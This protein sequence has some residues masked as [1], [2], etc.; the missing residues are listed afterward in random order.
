M[1]NYYAKQKSHGCTYILYNYISVKILANINYSD[2]KLFRTRQEMWVKEGTGY[3]GIMR[4]KETLGK[5]DG[6]IGNYIYQNWSNS[7]L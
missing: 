2:R 7:K 4:H 3:K 6:F 1:S 5:G